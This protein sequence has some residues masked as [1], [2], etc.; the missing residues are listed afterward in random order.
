MKVLHL[1][2]SSLPDWR[3]E[4]SAITAKR[5]GHDVFFAGENSIHNYSNFIFNKI[6]Q[7][8]WNFRAKYKF[9]FFYQIVKKKINNI[10]KEIRPDIIHAHNILPA[11]IASE[12]DIPFVF[13]DHEYSS[14]HGKVIYESFMIRESLDKSKKNKIRWIA[15]KSLKRHMSKLWT[16]WEKEIVSNYPTIT[17]SEKI[18]EEFRKYNSTNKIFVV[19]NVPMKNEIQNLD[20]PEYHKELSSVYMGS[21]GW[22]TYPYPN[23]DMSG[24]LETFNNN[25]IGRL[26]ILGWNDPKKE[27]SKIKFH[28]YNSR[29]NMFKILRKSSIGLVPWK[30]HWSHYYVNPNKTFEYVHAGLLVICTADL[31]TIYSNLGGNCILVE[32][33]NDLVQKLEYFSENIEELNKLR[34]KSFNFAKDNLIW[35]KY[36]KNIINVYNSFS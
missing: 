20:N 8:H 36:D 10:I 18:A 13:D 5:E 27:T 24:L 17:V 32:D 30:K 22:A 23:R 34:L 19:P 35:E 33:Y 1:S 11:K 14:M 28:G 26:D 3:I 29:D 4:K 25:E 9:P 15:R 6:Y 2:E 7:F 12:F 31:K 16:E 21:D